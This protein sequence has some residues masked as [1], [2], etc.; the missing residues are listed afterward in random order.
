M[1]ICLN[2]SET[3]QQIPKHQQLWNQQTQTKAAVTWNFNSSVATGLRQN[4]CWKPGGRSPQCVP[5]AGGKKKR[6]ERT[7]VQFSGGIGHRNINPAPRSRTKQSAHRLRDKVNNFPSYTT[8]PETNT[9][10][11]GSGQDRGLGLCNG[12][13]MTPQPG[14]SIRRRKERE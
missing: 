7:A 5:Y 13:P 11:K 1:S 9:T 10:I 3:E 6:Q 12:K 2:G 4:H 14:G 8:G